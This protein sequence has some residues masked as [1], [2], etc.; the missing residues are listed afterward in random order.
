MDWTRGPPIGKGSFAAVYLASSAT[1]ELF[2]LKSTDLSSSTSLQK[3]HCLISQLSSPYIVKCFG[4]GTTFESRK[5]VYNVFLEYVSGGTISEQIARQGG[6]LDERLIQSYARQILLGLSY[7]HCNGIVHCDIKGQNILIGEDEGLKI[8]DFGCAKWVESSKFS[9][10]M[11]AGTP[12]Y[13][14]P[15]VARG[16]EQSFPADIWALGC[17]VIEMATGSNPWSEMKDPASALYRIAYSGDV[18][19][20]PAWFSDSGKDFLSKCLTTDRK[21]RWTAGELLQ[22]HFL[23]ENCG[24][25]REFIRKSPTSVMDQGFWDLLEVSDSSRNATD[26][27]S[28]LESPANR[29]NGLLTD[30]PSSS[31]WAAAE[32]DDWVTVRC[33]AEVDGCRNSVKQDSEQDAI[34]SESDSFWGEDIQTSASVEDPLFDRFNNGYTDPSIR[35]PNPSWLKG[36]TVRQPC[37]HPSSGDHLLPKS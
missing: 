23:R 28:N 24:E 31:G 25:I 2:A 26:I 36:H 30:A 34:A 7:L 32:D 6:S 29:I 17:T 33:G 10:E 8:A 5:P 12:A 4:S 16:E 3:E 11:F 37:T 22:H 13:M 35:N 21:E 19:E 18:P 15:E 27:S 14:A 20:I 1:G 9:K